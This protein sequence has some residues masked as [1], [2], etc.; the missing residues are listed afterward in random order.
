VL[1]V[2]VER[3]DGVEKAIELC[4]VGEMRDVRQPT[5]PAVEDVAD[6][7]DDGFDRTCQP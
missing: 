3:D 7:E 1:G 5:V 2:P 6:V 4:R